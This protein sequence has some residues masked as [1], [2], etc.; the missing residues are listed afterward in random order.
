MAEN[1]PLS[2]LQHYLY[3]PRQCALIHIEHVWVENRLTA[4]GRLLHQRVDAGST[5]RRAGILQNRSVPV[6][7]DRLSLYGVLDMVEMRTSSDGREAPYPVEYKRGRPKIEDWDRA[8]LCAQAMCLE[9]MIGT[10]IDEGAIFYG[11]PR[12][13]ETVVFRTDLREK[14]ENKCKEMHA[15][16]QEGKTPPPVASKKHRCKNCSLGQECMPRTSKRSSV[17]NYLLKGL[18]E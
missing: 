16:I 13:R 11:R 6:R 9:E 15:M 1:L 3:C 18:N 8:Q 12:R 10:L 5:D 14:V 4:E 17:E 7:S 2:A